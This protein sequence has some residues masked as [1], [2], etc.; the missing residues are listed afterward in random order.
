MSSTKLC[1]SQNAFQFNKQF[2]EQVKG[3]A[4]GNLL[5]PFSAEVF[6]AYLKHIKKILEKIP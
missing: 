6:W 5:F 2:Y 1:M 3:T 4:M